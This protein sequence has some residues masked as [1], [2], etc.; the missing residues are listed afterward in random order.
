MKIIFNH[1]I[2]NWY[3][4]IYDEL[5]RKYIVILPDNY[6]NLKNRDIIVDLNSLEKCVKENCDSDFIFDFEGNLH[7]LISWKIKKIKMPLVIFNTNTSGRDYLGKLTAL[8]KLWYVEY[9]AKPLLEK[10]HKDNLIYEGMAANPYI[11]HPIETEKV[12]DI[13][14]FGQ[15]YGKRG[16]RLNLIKN[17]CKKHNL[18]YYFPVGHGAK[19]PWTFE[20]INKLYNQSKINLAFAQKDYHHGRRVNLRTFEICMSG[21]FQ[22]LQYAS[23]VEE[24][25]KIDKELVC[26][27]N[28]SDLF[29]KILYYLE[30]EDEREKIAKNGIKRA[31]KEHT[32]SVRF[33]KIYS[34]LKQKNTTNLSKYYV[35][36]KN[37]L[38]KQVVL[39]IDNLITTKND[40]VEFI[41]KQNGFK[42]KNLK[43]KSLLK[44][45]DRESVVYY[46][47]NLTDFYYI[48]YYGKIMVIIKKIPLKSKISLNDWD[49]LKKKL[50]LTENLDYSVPQFGILTNV[51]DWIIKDFKKNKWLKEI[52]NKKIIRY[53]SNFISYVVLR[54][55]K[56]LDINYARFTSLNLAKLIS[57]SKKMKIKKFIFRKL[58]TL[59]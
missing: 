1:T 17:F 2:T 48:S 10:Y 21:N 5:K 43:K 30:N 44:L 6:K 16:Y 31:I 3:W 38:K 9:F 37:L 35:K 14:F 7:D 40:I 15:H 56:T 47:P 25:F 18:K 24:Y 11:F 39:D 26:W 12:F 42:K 33:E 55:L 51:Y 46:K 23:C 4:Q 28:E 45:R 13:S 50:Y 19:L 22:L 53:R 58:V 59:Y 29:E 36:Y 27:N 54:V 20:D 49:D 41:I 57:N 32:W 34:I 52:P 8:A